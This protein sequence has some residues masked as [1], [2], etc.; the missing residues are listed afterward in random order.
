MRT[1]REY[2]EQH[3]I[4]GSQQRIAIMAY[5]QKHKSH[6]TVDEIFNA[7][8]PT[9]PTLSKTTI[10]NT[11]KLFEQKGAVHSIHVDEKTTRYDAWMDHHAHFHCIK[12]NTIIDLPLQKEV[13][14]EPG[15]IILNNEQLK[16][17]TVIDTKIYLTGICPLCKTSEK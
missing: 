17:Y 15:D 1:T 7:L 10:Y 4:R 14:N 8:Y 13:E 11:L 5:L 2:L 12:C 6:P 9:L 16:K 3:N